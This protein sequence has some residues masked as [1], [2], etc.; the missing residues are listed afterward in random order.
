MG[1][2]MKS[3]INPDE[4]GVAV[5]LLR[6]TRIRGEH[7]ESGDVVEV[8]RSE[9]AFLIGCEIAAFAPEAPTIEVKDEGAHEEARPRGRPRK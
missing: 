3:Y 7:C 1:E 9:A 6:P 2:M 4:K 5:K 8:E